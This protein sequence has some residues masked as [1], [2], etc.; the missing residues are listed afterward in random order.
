MSTIQVG[1]R[2]RLDDWDY[3]VVA[4]SPSGDWVSFSI[5]RVL[6]WHGLRPV[7]WVVHRS[8]VLSWTR[9]EP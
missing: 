1:D 3:D 2:F 5:G 8:V 6:P 9:V 7:A 4:V